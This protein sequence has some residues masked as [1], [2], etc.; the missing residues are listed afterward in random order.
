MGSGRSGIRGELG[1]GER[2][3]LGIAFM[4]TFGDLQAC[5]R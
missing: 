1:V 3:E 2:V 5:R 4:A